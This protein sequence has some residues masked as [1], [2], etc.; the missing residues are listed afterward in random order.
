MILNLPDFDRP[1]DAQFRSWLLQECGAVNPPSVFPDGQIRRFRDGKRK[2]LT[3]RCVLYPSGFGWY[4]NYKDGV[5]LDF[6]PRFS[7]ELSTEE[8]KEFEA[9]SVRER[10]K[11]KEEENIK[12]LKVAKECEEYLET[13]P[14]ATDANPY[15]QRKGIKAPSGCKEDKG[16]LIVP[17][18]N[19]EGDI[20]SYQKVPEKGDKL[21]ATGGKVSGGFFQIGE[22]PAFLCEGIATAE[23][24]HEAS[25][26]GVVC[27]F[28]ANNLP[29][30][31]E[32]FPDCVVIADRDKSKTGEDKARETGL[33]FFVVPEM[34]EGSDA[35]DYASI[36]GL[37]ALSE[38]LQ[39]CSRPS[40]FVRGG[41]LLRPCGREEYLI[42]KLIPKGQSLIG[43]IGRSGCGKTSLL[44]G[45]VLSVVTGQDRWCGYR[46]KQGKVAYLNAE[47]PIGFRKRLMFWC[48]EH[49]GIEKNRAS[50]NENLLVSQGV[51]K[52][53][54]EPED[55]KTI[56]RDIKE[57]H[58]KPDIIVIDTVNRYMSGNEND[59]ADVSKFIQGCDKLK[60]TFN[61]AVIFVHHVG[62]SENAQGRVRGSSV[63]Q[64]SVDYET[65]MASQGNGIVS[66][67]QTKNK[68]AE[69]E[70]EF[71]M[72]FYSGDIQGW[73]N[74]YEEPV[75]SAFLVPCDAPEVKK[76][77]QE[78]QDENL[79]VAFFQE[80]GFIDGNDDVILK[81][82]HLKKHLTKSF[83]GQKNQAGNE[84]SD[85]EIS[86]R[87]SNETNP[88]QKGKL[89]NRLVRYGFVSLIEDSTENEGGKVSALI[90]Q[91]KESKESVKRYLTSQPEL[92]DT[93]S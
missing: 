82:E 72:R 57:A 84:L 19:Q 1:I 35:N 40:M 76:T 21:F 66:I 13:L 51:T 75:R 7:R 3:G 26:R 71:Y 67:I 5:K 23:S 45:Q 42:E 38:W 36:N 70:P 31:A 22:N 10:E 61:C 65:L 83:K 85:N 87:V 20:V 48:Q 39:G 41:E 4:M 32:F 68:E 47:S 34:S 30:V 53:L 91:D 29:K 18:R 73:L 15:C 49:G 25:G 33:P 69:R 50:I 60:T 77:K 80:D 63:F 56:E 11:F 64:A 2:G 54:N 62:W 52:H 90:L 92:D 93:S 78:T 24:I 59:T 44:I 86:K 6:K 8:W 43:T 12:H 46:V 81:I 14:E 89:I 74:D 17:V 55:L 16:F 27:C 79:I 58:F 9:R 37:D 28:S 88:K